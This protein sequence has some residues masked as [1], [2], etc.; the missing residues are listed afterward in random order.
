MGIL[1]FLPVVGSAVQ[2]LLDLIPDPNARAKA[3][4]EYQQ[5]VLA[6]AAKAEADQRDINKTEA[7]SN[8]LFVSG[9]RPGIGWVCALALAFQYLV[10]P[11]VSWAA[12]VWWP[13]MPALPGLDDSLWQLMFGMLGMGGLRTLEK[14][15]GVGK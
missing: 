1:E 6:I 15:K 8:S 13:A 5:T 9:W 3:A 12:S 10:R 7:A 4:E 2:K 11:L 14:T